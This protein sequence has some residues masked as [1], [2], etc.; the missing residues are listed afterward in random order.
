MRGNFTVQYFNSYPENFAYVLA[1]YWFHV[2][3]VQLLQRPSFTLT[4]SLL[5]HTHLFSVSL[6]LTHSASTQQR[7]QKDN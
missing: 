5:I 2:F 3:L 6:Y 1:I 4:H 7:D